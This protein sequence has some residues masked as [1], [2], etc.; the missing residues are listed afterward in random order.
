MKWKLLFRVQR[1]GF[2]KLRDPSLGVPIMGIEDCSSLGSL[3]EATIK[4]KY[5]VC[6]VY[7]FQKSEAS[8]CRHLV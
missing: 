4:R 5:Q 8:A 3:S 2:Q 7:A 6:P 1:S